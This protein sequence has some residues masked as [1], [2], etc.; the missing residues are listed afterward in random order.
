MRIKSW[1]CC[2]LF[3]LLPLTVSAEKAKDASL[4]ELFMESGIE[5]QL[6]QMPLLLEDGFTRAAQTDGAVRKLPD[7]IV[8]I[9]RR[10]MH[11][12]FEVARMKEVVLSELRESLTDGDV[13]EL[14]DWFSSP[15]GTRIARL[16]EAA[17]TPEGVVESGKYASQLE[18]SPSLDA[19]L[20][21]LKKLD[22]AAKITK[23]SVELAIDVQAAVAFAMVSTMPEERR[24]SI[25]DITALL[26]KD[27][28][29]I[30]AAVRSSSLAALLYTYRS[31]TDQEIQQLLA[32]AVSPVGSKFSSA[33]MTMLKKV[34][35]EGSVKWGKSIGEAITQEPA[36]G[37][38]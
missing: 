16:E 38:V 20:A 17:S 19:R 24:P 31:L 12:A 37:G 10:S 21:I 36:Q 5:K 18:N 26:E 3:L 2:V 25:K 4:R 9:M 14:L 29:N 8:Q 13:K 32:F 6:E 35:L 23:S 1:F 34:I 15:L 11:D 30:E 7:A 33:Q 27:R 22:D 28:P